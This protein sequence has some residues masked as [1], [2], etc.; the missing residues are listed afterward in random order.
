M[1]PA[2]HQF[3]VFAA[4]VCTTPITNALVQNDGT[5]TLAQ[6]YARDSVRFGEKKPDSRKQ[7]DDDDG[8]REG[9]QNGKRRADDRQEQ[10]RE[11]REQRRDAREQ[12]KDDRRDDR[13]NARDE[14]RDNRRDARD[15]RRDNRRG[16]GERARDNQRQRIEAQRAEQI[17]REKARREAA[18][19]AEAER[20]EQ[21]RRQREQAE[22]QRRQQQ[23]R[24]ADRRRDASPRRDA[25]GFAGQRNNARDDDDSR[26]RREGRRDR[27]ERRNRSGPRTLRDLKQG[28]R[29][30]RAA[31]NR[32]IIEEPGNRVIVSR[33]NRIV[34]QRD[35]SARLRRLMPGARS[36]RMRGNRTRTVVR[37]P[38]GVEIISITD[39]DGR[40][41]R[42]I[43][44]E[45]GG[46][47]RLLIDNRRRR[48]RR[49]SGR[50]LAIGAGIG[51][52]VVAGALLL[53]SYVDVPEPRINIARDR[54]IVDYSDASEDDL[55]EAFSAPPVGSY[56]ERY[57]LDE[58]R[59]THH[60]R[61]R[62]R[63]VDLDDVTFAFGAWDVDPDEYDK[64][65][66]LAR[67][68]RRVI[69]RDPG[70]V[71][72]VEGHT[73]AVGTRVDNITLS[74]RRAETV[75]DLLVEEFDVPF[76]NLVAQGY[77]ED[78][79][80]I[81]TEQPERQ[82]RRVAIRR[83]TPLLDRDNKVSDYDEEDSEDLE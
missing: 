33:G 24:A 49:G 63:R 47:E 17:R 31:G 3:L 74:D 32:T 55:Y 22:Q 51:A 72:M 68:M 73:D 50:D 71:F 16:F 12:R 20:A 38:N 30:R 52:G 8:N 44:R 67:A 77:G 56:N 42:R 59:A 15:E 4:L 28:R 53:D 6:A 60:L 1:I 78:Y 79:L 14:R 70:E 2:R 58:I 76:E 57:T 66:R 5:M 64:L 83:I 61:Q 9:K 21:A 41:I 46:R 11:N 7:A 10:R 26:R 39:N 25:P 34:I 82:N 29:E 18:Q 23:E 62:M 80:K 27:A 75:L 69:R 48:N 45:A 43:R 35:E 36:E 54:Y 81:V 37:R 13:R 19:K 40:L 65:E